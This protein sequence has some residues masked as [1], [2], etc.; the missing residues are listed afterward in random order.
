MKTV[1]TVLVTGGAGFIGTNLCETL[2]EQNHKVI[3]LDNFFTGSWENI[4][5]LQENKNFSVI[6]HDICIPIDLKNIDEIYNIACPASPIHYQKDPLFTIKTSVFGA[7]NMLELARKN[8]AKI[9]QTST[10]EVYGDPIIH[11]Q[12]ESY[13]GNVNPIGPRACY[14]E[15]KRCAETIFTNYI[16]QYSLEV[17]IAR[18][19]NTYGPKMQANDGRVVSNFVIQAL[20]N[21]DLSV[22]GTGNQTRSFCFISDLVDGL[23]KLMATDKDCS[24]PINL[25]NPNEFTIMEL[26]K[27]IIEL[28]GGTTHIAFHNLPIDDPKQ[29]RPD[30]TLANTKLNWQPQVELRDGLKRTIEYFANKLSLH[31]GTHDGF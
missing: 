24:G 17:K 31:N 25:G 14:D 22:Y 2:L 13:W 8:N 9:L 11:P 4:A 3:C 23:I 20:Q 12:P 29:R 16:H 10:S 30:I 27:M 15:S 18:I 6:E 1:K 28:V 19:F 21:Q 26:A 5:P 7:F